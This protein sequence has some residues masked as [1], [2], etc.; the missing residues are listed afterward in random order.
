VFILQI[1]DNSANRDTLK[2]KNNCNIKDLFSFDVFEDYSALKNVFVENH[3][4]LS[5]IDFVP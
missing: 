5:G 1:K 3:D 4:L 2:W